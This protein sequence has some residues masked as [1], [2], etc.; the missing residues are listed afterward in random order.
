MDAAKSKIISIV[1]LTILLVLCTTAISSVSAIT[2]SDLNA[3][4][5]IVNGSATTGHP[6]PQFFYPQSHPH[7][8]TAGPGAG[9]LDDR[10]ARQWL[11][12]GYA[13]PYGMSS[14]GGTEVLI[15]SCFLLY[16]PPI[17]PAL[18]NNLFFCSLFFF[19]LAIHLQTTLLVILGIGVIGLPFLLL[20][21]SAFT[22]SQG[23]NFMS[24]NFMSPATTTVAGRK[25]RDAFSSSLHPII[26][27]KLVD[28]MK[29]FSTAPDK[30][31]L[32]LNNLVDD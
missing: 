10:I 18:S 9:E 14:W 16:A 5:R 15:V 13:S 19:S 23:A 4:H 24:P 27:S 25:R 20:I 22:G 26:Q 11:S 31:A 12:G 28:I 21:F 2:R 6:H 1:P 30:M 29:K 32:L 17:S 8:S 7:Q 3:A